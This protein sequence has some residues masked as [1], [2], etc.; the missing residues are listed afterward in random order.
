M[1][2][3]NHQLISRHGAL[4]C[5]CATAD[6]S[7]RLFVELARTLLRASRKVSLQ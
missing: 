1:G 5:A 2:L 4:D 3:N 7:H 6:F